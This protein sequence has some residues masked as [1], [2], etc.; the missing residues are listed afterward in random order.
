MLLVLNWIIG[1]QS[2]QKKVLDEVVE[3]NIETLKLPFKEK[4]FDCILFADVLEHLIDPLAVLKK[5][6]KTFKSQWNGYS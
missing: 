3:G 5:T 4:R 6:R 1:Q 2:R